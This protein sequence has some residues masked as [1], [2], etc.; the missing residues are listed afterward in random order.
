[1]VAVYRRGQPPQGPQPVSCELGDPAALARLFDEQ[2]PDAVVHAAVLSRA[3]DCEARP[4]E[5]ERVN[6]QLPGELARLCAKRRLRLVALST[7][8]VFAGVRPFVT[9]DAA[10]EPLSVYGR[11]KLAGERAVLAALPSAVIARIA[12]VAG[13][14]HGPKATS[15]EQVVQALAAGR[16]PRLYTDEYRTPVDAESV[17]DAVARLVTGSASGLFHLGGP[18][19]LSRYQLGLRVAAA[20]GLRP[21][22]V[23]PALQRDHPGLERRAP[24]VSLDSTRARREL[25]WQPRPVDQAIRDSRL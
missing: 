13:R 20:F 10:A 11:T 21:D 14:G 19:R 22:A 6:A 8:L 17:A 5:A 3:E 1:M 2:A 12:L 25:G 23:V 24:D 15:T 4:D 18:E 9:E 7:D 16:S